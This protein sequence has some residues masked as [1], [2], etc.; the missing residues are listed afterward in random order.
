MTQK[1]ANPIDNLIQFKR[2]LKRKK[3]VAIKK[4]K[5]ITNPEKRIPKNEPILDQIER[6]A[7]LGAIG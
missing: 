1:I 3:G 4:P 2:T 6:F 5:I 7:R